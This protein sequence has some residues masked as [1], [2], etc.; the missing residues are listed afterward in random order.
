MTNNNQGVWAFQSPKLKAPYSEEEKKALEKEKKA[1]YES[2]KSG[3]SRF[4][5]SMSDEH[6][7][8]ADIG[9]IWHSRQMF[10]LQVKEGD[11]IVHINLPKWGKCVAVKVV[12]AYAFDDGL[13]LPWRAEGEKQDF[14]HCFKI[15]VGSIIEFDRRDEKII[16]SVNLTPRY[17]YHRV[18]KVEEFND[19]MKYLKGNTDIGQDDHLKNVIQ[20]KCLLVMSELIHDMNQSKKLESFLGDVLKK[21]PGVKEV[22]E[23]G[24]GWGT[25][26]GADLIVDMCTELG[27]EHRV[28]IQ[29]K[30]YEGVQNKVDAVEQVKEGIK[31]FEG[32]EGMIITTAEASEALEEKVQEAVD[33]GFKIVILDSTYLA[34]FVIKHAPELLFNTDIFNT[35]K[36]IV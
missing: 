1:L 22:K 13:E 19:S 36:Q 18:Y 14:R 11:W 16:P 29:V 20:K 17:R 24:S 32:T 2:I 35:D 28:I 12:E 10:L 30:S 21:V 9:S 27:H 7:L 25:D 26:H 34:K 23:N 3:K 15:D 8:K 5:W 31:K 33:E 4:G 6:N